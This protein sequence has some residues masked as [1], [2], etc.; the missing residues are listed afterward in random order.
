MSDF[1][2]V[3]TSANDDKAKNSNK[4]GDAPRL[5]E[6]VESS[7]TDGNWKTEVKVGSLVMAFDRKVDLNNL[8]EGELDIIAA[9]RFYFGSMWIVRLLRLFGFHPLGL[10]S[11]VSDNNVVDISIL[12]SFWIIFSIFFK[13]LV[14]LAIF[15]YFFQDI[16]RKGIT[17]AFVSLDKS[18][19]VCEEI[20]QSLNGIYKADARGNWETSSDFM[21]QLNNFYVN[22]KGLSYTQS[23]WSEIM[24]I[25][26]TEVIAMG[27]KTSTRDLAY[28]VVA[29]ASYAA[30]YNSKESG[31]GL[32]TSEGNLFFYSSA[33]P[34]ILFSGYPSSVTWT[35][36]QGVCQ[37]TYDTSSNPKKVNNEISYDKTTA[38][39][40]IYT[41]WD[42]S[43]QTYTRPCSGIIYPQMLGTPDPDNDE[44][45]YLEIDMNS[46][47]TALAVNMGIRKVTHLVK[48]PGDQDRIQLIQNMYRLSRISYAMMKATG[49]YFDDLL[50]PMEP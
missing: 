9:K 17:N 37:N 44:Y 45:T 15:A 1:E 27:T 25:I 47:S 6:I 48:V 43:Y 10:K 34:S 8:S 13:S 5:L 49:S 3:S 26:E 35:S 16:Y 29:L 28:N 12:P 19:G 40:K 4:K 30:Y 42:T 14:I 18:S 7:G 23:R 38:T 32:S 21:Y 2:F 39:V 50:A 31:L 41:T 46:V 24:K 33:E 36:D 11:L 20:P 22:L